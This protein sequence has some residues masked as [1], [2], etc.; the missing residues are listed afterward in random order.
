MKPPIFS[1]LGTLSIPSSLTLLSAPDSRLVSIISLPLYFCAAVGVKVT[2]PSPLPAGL[3]L[4]LGMRA[5]SQLEP[6]LGPQ[7]ATPRVDF[8]F[9]EF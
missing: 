3:P 2:E 6:L 9:E 8:H 4:S 7:T 1:L 5:S